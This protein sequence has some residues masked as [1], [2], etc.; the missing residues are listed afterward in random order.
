MARDFEQVWSDKEL[1]GFES[2]NATGVSIQ[3]VLEVF[4]QRGAP[5]SEATFRKYVQL[6]LLPRSIRVGRKGK[7]RG[8]Q[9]FYPATVVR[10]IDAVRGL[11]S[12]GYTIEEIQTEFLFVTAEL[13]QLRVGLARVLTAMERSLRNRSEE[14]ELAKKQLSEAKSLGRD[15]VMKLDALEKR[16]SLRARMARA[17][18]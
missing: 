14:D 13:E 5:I 2:A 12:Q 10:R 8:S 11:M 4:E 7:H 16:V 6:G 3:T 9:G 1:E 17:V 18:V 15:L